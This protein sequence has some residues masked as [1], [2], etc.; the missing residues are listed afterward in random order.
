MN[1]FKKGNRMFPDITAQHI[2]ECKGCRHAVTEC[3]GFCYM[4]EE[5]PERLPCGQHDK[6]KAQRDANAK[7]FAKNPK[8]VLDNIEAFRL[9]K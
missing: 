8:L 3:D 9:D 6:F 5:K 2:T 1:S 4:F 7:I